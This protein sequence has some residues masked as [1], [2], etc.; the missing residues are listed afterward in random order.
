MIIVRWLTH[1]HTL[2]LHTQITL[3]RSEGAFV[4]LLISIR[5]DVTIGSHLIVRNNI[6]KTITKPVYRVSIL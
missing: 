2:H 6:R 1:T 3:R 5:V 4:F